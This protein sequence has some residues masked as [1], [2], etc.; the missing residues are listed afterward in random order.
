MIRRGNSKNNATGERTTT[1]QHVARGVSPPTGPSRVLSS[2]ALSGFFILDA[3]LLCSP[4]ELRRPSSREFSLVKETIICP[5]V[6]T[7]I[8]AGV[9]D[10]I[11]LQIVLGKLRNGG[12][13]G[14]QSGCSPPRKGYDASV[15]ARVM[16][17]AGAARVYPG[18]QDF[19]LEGLQAVRN[20]RFRQLVRL[21][22]VLVPTQVPGRA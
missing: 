8:V 11:L 10:S 17:S 15:R 4:D 16:N 2:V 6:S 9:L 14:V 20:L 21:K 22:A 7:R 5:A 1:E 18:M 13:C 12:A 3:P 19:P